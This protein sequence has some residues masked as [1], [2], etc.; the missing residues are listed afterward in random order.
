[1]THASFID[2]IRGVGQPGND[3]VERHSLTA[4]VEAWYTAV[5]VWVR[6][7]LTGLTP[8]IAAQGVQDPGPHFFGGKLTLLKYYHTIPNMS[9]PFVTIC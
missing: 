2:M 6:R 5:G 9:I 3:A 7:F 1:M 4:R 8:T